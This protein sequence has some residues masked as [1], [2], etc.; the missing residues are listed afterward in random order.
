MDQCMAHAYNNIDTCNILTPRAYA[1][2]DY[3]VHCKIYYIYYTNILQKQRWNNINPLVVSQAVRPMDLS[4]D[5]TYLVSLDWISVQNG[6][7][8]YFEF[9]NNNNN[10]NNNGPN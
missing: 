5:I 4:L 8:N 3:S 9:I 2:K 10:N 1:E 7:F 6:V